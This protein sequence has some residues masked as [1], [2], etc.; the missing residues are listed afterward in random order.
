MSNSNMELR[1]AAYPVGSPPHQGSQEAI[2]IQA[3]VTYF[4]KASTVSGRGNAQNVFPNQGISDLVFLG[5]SPLKICSLLLQN[6]GPAPVK[7]NT[8][9]TSQSRARPGKLGGRS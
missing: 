9:V 1:L 5:L 4:Q 3:A 2:E 8:V 6:M 7:L